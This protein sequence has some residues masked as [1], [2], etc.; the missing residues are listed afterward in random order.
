MPQMID[1]I[2]GVP[3]IA[4]HSFKG[5]VGRTLSLLTAVRALSMNSQDRPVQL[6]IVDADM[7]APGLTFLAKEMGSSANF[8]L[9]DA[10]ALVH[11]EFEWREKCLPC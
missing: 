11:G 7:E 8:S 10:M 2:A 1:D 9:V 3:V 6:L 5:G 4:F